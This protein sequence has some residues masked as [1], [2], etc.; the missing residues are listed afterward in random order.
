MKRM[1]L[2]KFFLASRTS[3]VRKEICGI[4]QH[5]SEMLYEYWERG[6]TTFKVVNEVVVVDNQRL[7]NKITKLTS[8]VRQLAIGQCHKSPP[9]RVCGICAFEEHPID[10]C[11]TFQEIELNSAKVAVVMDGQQYRQPHNQY[12]NL[13]YGLNPKQHPVQQSSLENLVKQ[14]ATHNIQFQE[15]LYSKGSR[16]VPLQTILSPQANMIVITLKSGKELP[17]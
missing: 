5:T 2:E 8:F 9:A 4:R 17:Q 15:N 7:E 6:S 10:T 1:F 14:M 3:S 16:K 12:S 11:P 13:R